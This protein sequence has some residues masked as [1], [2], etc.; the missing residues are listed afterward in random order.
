MNIEVHR[1]ERIIHLEYSEYV[2]DEKENLKRKEEGRISPL[3]ICAQL[4][5]KK[6]IYRDVAGVEIEEEV[7]YKAG[8]ELRHVHAES[9]TKR[10]NKGSEVATFVEI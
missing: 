7:S 9:S 5:A 6:V 2:C 4:K 10:R 3:Y 8:C 1:N